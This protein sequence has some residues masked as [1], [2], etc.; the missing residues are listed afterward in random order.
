MKRSQPTDFAD[1]YA[2]RFQLRALAA[3][4][5][6]LFGEVTFLAQD[7]A[8]RPPGGPCPRRDRPRLP[9]DGGPQ[10]G[11]PPL[12]GTISPSTA[13]RLTPSRNA[14]I[15]L[16][17]SGAEP[18]PIRHPEV[19]PAQRSRQVS[20]PAPPWQAASDPPRMRCTI[21]GIPI[22]GS[23]ASEPSLCPAGGAGGEGDAVRPSRV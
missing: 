13:S 21:E 11:P 7:Q 23:S 3:C 8:H 4:A 15:V 9:A 10:A 16:A 6:V 14:W 1:T 12:S 19:H 22:L 18:V 5:Q 2:N 17:T 20:Q